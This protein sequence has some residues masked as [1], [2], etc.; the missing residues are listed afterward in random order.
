VTGREAGWTQLAEHLPWL[1]GQGVYLAAAGTEPVVSGAL[2]AAGFTLATAV[3]VGTRYQPGVAGARYQPVAAALRLPSTAG[4]N[5]D[6]LADSMRD[7]PDRWPGT[8]RLALLVRGAE[9]L[10]Q[11]DLLAW[12][13]LSLVLGQ[14]TGSLWNERRTVFETVFFVPTGSF[15]ADSPS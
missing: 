5:L 15:G 12:L 14:A 7:L 9:T 11:A 13:Q 8:G 4:S 2:S 6:A 3:Y 1:R 10:I